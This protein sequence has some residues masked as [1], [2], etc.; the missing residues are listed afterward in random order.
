VP[1]TT[2]GLDAVKVIAD[3]SQHYDD[4]DVC[5]PRSTAADASMLCR[6]IMCH[7]R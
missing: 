1:Y 6:P 5:G 4:Y 7:R 3:Y 2:I